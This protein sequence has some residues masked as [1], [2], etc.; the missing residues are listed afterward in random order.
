MNIRP[1][2]GCLK[3]GQDKQSPCVQKDD[4]DKIYAAYWQA[5]VLVLA[6]PLYYWSFSAQLKAAIDR[7]FAVTEANNH[8]TPFKQ[9]V[10]LIAAEDD[11]SENFAPMK[12]Y[13]HS[14][15]SNLGWQD[16][17]QVLAGGVLEVGDIKGKPC[18]EEAEKLG[19]AIK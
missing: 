12:A 6:S 4:M 1:C 11:S 8:Q 19:A 10:M 7:I 5:D 9:C 18:L 14:L 3:G 15:L 2:I 13:Y 16:A 17:G